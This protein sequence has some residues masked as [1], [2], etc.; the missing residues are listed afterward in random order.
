MTKLA[1]VSMAAGEVAPGLYA[2]VDLARYAVALKRCRDCIVRVTGG[3]TS[4]PGTELIAQTQ[5]PEEISK[6][7]PFTF[8]EEQSYALEFGDLSISI[9]TNGAL[10]ENLSVLATIID[11]ISESISGKPVR[12]IETAAAH[13]LIVGQSI[14]IQGVVGSGSVVCNGTWNVASIVSATKFRILGSGG[15]FGNYDSGGEVLAPLAIVSPYSSADLAEL[16][17]TQSADVLT[18]THPDFPPYDFRRLS[19]N[20]F[21]IVEAEF[22]DGPFEESN[23]EPTSYV[24]ASA[25]TG[26]VTLTSTEDLFLATHVGAL[27]YIEQQ[28]GH[29]IPPWEPGKRLVGAAG[30]PVGLLRSSDGKNYRC[31]TNEV[32]ATEFVTGTIRP[33]HEYGVEP[34]GNG[35][36]ITGGADRAGVDW[37]YRDSCYGILRITAVAGPTS[38]TARVIR[39][40]PLSVV[41]GVTTAQGPWT[42][43][44]DGVDT[45]LATAGATDDNKY[46]YEVTL[47][48]EILDPSEYS[49][50]S[51]TDVLTFAIA[52]G[53]GVDVDAR[54]LSPNHRTN[55]WA[56]GAWSEENGYPA[57]VEYSDDRK[58][59]A[60]TEFQPQT[61]WMTRVGDYRAF[62]PAVPIVDDDPITVT[63]NSRQLNK[64]V[65]LVLLN[66]LII[67]TGRGAWRVMGGR[68]DV[69]TPTSISVKPQSRYGS[70][71]I[72]AVVIGDSALYIHPNGQTVYELFYTIERD[73]YI[74]SELSITSDHLLK[75]LPAVD[76][77]YQENPIWCTWIPREDGLVVGVTFHKEHEVN[78]WHLHDFG[79]IVES[80]CTVPENGESVLYMIVNRPLNGVDNRLVE[81]LSQRYPEDSLDLVLMDSALSYDGRNTS[82]ATMTLGG[83]GWTVDDELTLTCSAS[84]FDSTDVGD[85]V[86]IRS[87][88]DSVRVQIVGYTSPTLMQVN[89]LA[90]VPL[91]IQGLTTTDWDLGSRSFSG[92]DHL[93]GS[94]VTVVGDGAALGEFE[95]DSNGIIEVVESCV[96]VH[97]GLPYYP[98]IETLECNNPGGESIAATAK[99]IPS[100]SVQVEDTQGIWAG[101]DEDNLDEY[102]PREFEDMGQLPALFTG[103]A[104]IPITC[105]WSKTGRV[106]ITQRNPLPMTILAV[107][108]NVRVGGSS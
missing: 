17:Y 2:R 33:T 59:Y 27:F 20:S 23:T 48:G 9:F 12:T 8:S 98:L 52:P 4:R 73:G 67:M 64:I 1:Q 16:S 72:P 63:L 78:A 69:I 36:P 6:M 14:I 43:T 77:V 18:L 68:D 49:V 76:M 53:A 37:E 65:D 25:G 79:G 40:L 29:E 51:V 56:F 107:I 103:S 60:T 85:V 74:S 81:R 75:N 92:L 39:Q 83:S 10:V 87:G 54:Q 35:L 41:G 84:V 38:A 102:V 24:H 31:V 100:V 82:T 32:A 70:G 44:G 95:V 58:I 55:I 22:D 66:D 86:V 88:D 19:G 26:I 99:N 3:V 105:N 5:S 45:T 104:V 47:D 93:I 90:D 91:S 15:M 61:G 94:M 7:I 46:N 13:G 106:V 96:R 11:V 80:A 71:S 30:N 108:P 97:V 50:N 57:E 89:P 101:P 28:D 62:V 21:E 34:D 42:M